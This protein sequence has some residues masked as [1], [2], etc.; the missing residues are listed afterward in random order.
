MPLT[1]LLGVLGFGL[2]LASLVWQI[3]SRRPRLNVEIDRER[4]T[5]A[6]VEVRRSGTSGTESETRTGLSVVVEVSN[7]SVRPNTVTKI[8]VGGARFA[9]KGASQ[10]DLHH[11]CA[12]QAAPPLLSKHDRRVA[13]PLAVAGPL[14]LAAPPVA[15]K[16]ARGGFV[17]PSCWRSAVTGGRAAD[18][19]ER[20][21]HL[22]QTLPE[23]G[24]PP[25]RLICHAGNP[26]L[27]ASPDSAAARGCRQQRKTTER[28]GSRCR[29][30][31]RTL[32]VEG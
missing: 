30:R 21:R 12:R 3:L 9:R 11:Q 14:A 29:F 16:S 18:Q 15:G 23:I 26:P 8:E 28:P 1:E 4:S 31:V 6:T 7:V 20:H 5:F 24:S 19:S 22:R 32:A 13:D 2:A 27:I 25:T 17:L 10:C